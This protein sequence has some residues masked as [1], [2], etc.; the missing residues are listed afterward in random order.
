MIATPTPLEGCFMIKPNVFTDNRGMFFES[1]NKLKFEKAI[2]QKVDFVQDNQSESKR[3]VL[4]GLHFQ[5]GEH[6][7][8]KWVRVIKGEILDVVIDLRTDSKTFGQHFTIRLSEDN[9]KSLFI[10][11]GMAHGF[12]TLSENATF[13]YK[14]D[15]YYHQASESGI[16][17]NDETLNIDWE[18]SPQNIIL[19]EK[20][21]ELTTFKKLYP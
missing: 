19:S 8:A 3:G 2:G 13:S 10:P 20:D 21:M 15:N 18:I 7:Q 12:L 4:R 9:L 17:Y 11:K 6:A 5:K 1:Y 16:I 14:C